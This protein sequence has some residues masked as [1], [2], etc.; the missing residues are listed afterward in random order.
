MDPSLLLVSLIDRFELLPVLLRPEEAISNGPYTDIQPARTVLEELLYLLI[1]VFSEPTDIEALSGE[2]QVR[3]E[4]VHALLLAPLNYTDVMKHVTDRVN[5]DPAF[6][7]VLREV[8]D[9]RPPDLNA[10]GSDVGALYSLKKEC[11]PEVDPY[12][13]RYTRNQRE[14]AL[15]ILKAH[16]DNKGVFVPRKLQGRGCFA[17][18]RFT[19]ILASKVFIWMVQLSLR[20]AT[21]SSVN[22]DLAIADAV[23]DLALRLLMIAT[24]EQPAAFSSLAVAPACGS[25][26]CVSDLRALRELSAAKEHYEKVDY[27]LNEMFRL[28]PQAAGPAS[29]PE[30][31]DSKDQQKGAE[32]PEDAA[33]A[34]AEHKKAAAK[35]RQAAIMQQFSAQQQAFL[36]ANMS[37]EDD[38]DDDELD[39]DDD[40]GLINRNHGKQASDS[41]MREDGVQKAVD[42]SAVP[43]Q[44]AR[45]NKRKRKTASMG[46]CIVCQE[47][48]TSQNPWGSLALIQTSSLIRL[49][50]SGEAF[51]E[52]IY[53]TPTDLDKDAEHLRPFGL[54]GIETSEKEGKGGVSYGFPRK[55][56]KGL[57]A[58]ACGHMMHVSCFDTYCS[59]IQQRH[60]SQFTRNHPE[61]PDRKE[62]ICPLCKSLGNILLPVSDED[63]EDEPLV[64]SASGISDDWLVE[65]GQTLSM[66]SA[67]E[68]QLAYHL[69]SR[70]STGSLRPWKVS[71][72]LPTHNASFGFAGLSQSERKML[73]RLI[74]VVSPLDTESRM[75]D[76]SVE[77]RANSSL[78]HDLVA[79]TI[80]C[81]EIALRGKPT[82]TLGVGS[83]PAATAKLLR[84]L[85]SGL[86]RL[87]V[88]N[89]GTPRGPEL[90]RLA[91]LLLIFNEQQGVHVPHWLN[92][93]SFTLLVEAAA[94]APSDFYQFAALTFYSHL[95]RLS[96][97]LLTAD[98]SKQPPSFSEKQSL[99]ADQL[100]LA[101]YVFMIQ[102]ERWARSGVEVTPAMRLSARAA[103]ERAYAHALPF[104]RRAAILH[105]VI[106]PTSAGAATVA[107]SGQEGSELTRLLQVLRIPHPRELAGRRHG[108]AAQKSTGLSS[109]LEKWDATWLALTA[110]NSE[111]PTFDTPEIML[112]HPVIYEL[113]G[114]PKHIDM[115]VES[116]VT[117]KCRRC[118][119]V[120]SHPAICLLCGELVCQ[121]SH[122]CMDQDLGEE[123]L[124][125]ECNMHMWEY[126]FSVIHRLRIRRY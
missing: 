95:L 86:E 119:S 45:Q 38:E 46:S 118:R 111:Q 17:T 50:P 101:D 19:D 48:L 7:R 82:G 8:A 63:Y 44:E 10:A 84:S 18:S 87:V 51:L 99:T 3:R 113:L 21:S 15:K 80:S 30:G 107:T 110:A 60:S 16:F 52:E 23:V 75:L 100:A 69:L 55:T 49:L 20:F 81:I 5:E 27:V 92:R 96:R 35:A 62:F 61:N 34:V 72:S 58:S 73:E 9:F 70:D 42:A 105:G 88:L 53:E 90:A 109:M 59:S 67:Y 4:L 124:H 25:I 22:A 123:P 78:P 89:T 98:S 14:E 64:S 33:A 114:L 41:P 106:F 37:D 28:Q 112:E 79:Y 122:C 29:A 125:G 54:A 108:K 56:R 26:I 103:S 12:Y 77:G 93:D 74:S 2:Q 83:V 117:R 102:E 68:M 85:L 43:E 120:P 66:A 104:L 6:D 40:L 31:S 36:D 116:S 47:E 97:K 115:L 13:Y 71:D 126:V 94:V 57:F 24:V 121:Q 1:I 32:P 11:Y 65:A 39:E 76:D 91:L